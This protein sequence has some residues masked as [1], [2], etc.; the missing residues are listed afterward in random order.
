MNVI[1]FLISTVSSGGQGRILIK[2]VMHVYAC[3]IIRYS[4]EKT[5]KIYK[6]LNCVIIVDGDFDRRLDKKG[7]IL[8]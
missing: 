4:N 5:L 7:K 8:L 2:K 1:R 3:F 6:W